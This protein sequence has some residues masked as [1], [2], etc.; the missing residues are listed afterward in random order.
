MFKISSAVKPLGKQH[1]AGISQQRFTA[2]RAQA[3][4]RLK[5]AHILPCRKHG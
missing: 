3:R 5:F 2:S 4:P 1:L